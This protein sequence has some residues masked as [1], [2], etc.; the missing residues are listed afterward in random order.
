MQALPDAQKGPV[1]DAYAQSLSMMWIF[2]TC[3]SF[4]AFVAALNISK[5]EL[6]RQHE[7]VKTGLAGQEEGRKEREANRRSKRVSQDL[8]K[9]AEKGSGGVGV[10]S[11]GDKENA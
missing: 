2:Y 8:M 7:N 3:T 6:S 4:L 5:K 1:L 9:D 11:A 10:S